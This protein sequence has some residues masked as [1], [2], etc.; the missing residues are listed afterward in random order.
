MPN[1]HINLAIS[2]EKLA[3]LIQSGQLCAADFRCLDQDSK[4]KVWQLCL[5]CCSNRVGCV[6][7]CAQN[8]SGAVNNEY[9]SQS[10][11]DISIEQV[12]EITSTPN[13]FTNII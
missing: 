11:N 5:L 9:F 6:K 8:C 7:P 1:T 13:K 3:K 10:D 2:A 12:D 4:Q